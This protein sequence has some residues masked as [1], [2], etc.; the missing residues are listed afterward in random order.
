MVRE[1]QRRSPLAPR[2]RSLA[3]LAVAVAV[4]STPGP[5]AAEF[6]C[7]ASVDYH[8]NRC[9][10]TQV[11]SV[12]KEAGAAVC[13]DYARR[14]GE[15]CRPDW[16]KFKTCDDFA[17]RFETLLVEACAAHRVS[18]KSCRAWGDAYGAGERN[19]CQ[20]KRATY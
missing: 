17:R 10:S 4:A 14:I 6:R 1:A 13:T 8:A 7:S 2:R 20:R 16:D 3:A 12:A 11:T 15:S 19:R 5:A 9:A 18:A